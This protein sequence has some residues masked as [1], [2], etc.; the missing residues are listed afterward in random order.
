MLG[1]GGVNSL[2]C[3]VEG[4]AICSE[5]HSAEWPS[6]PYMLGAPAEYRSRGESGPGPPSRCSCWKV[7][8]SPSQGQPARLPGL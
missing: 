6:Y 7:I 3:W 8:L 5:G 1:T 4:Q 2:L